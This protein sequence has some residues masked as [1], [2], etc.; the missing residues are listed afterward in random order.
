MRF[1]RVLIVASLTCSFNTGCDRDRHST[2]SSTAS[3]QPANTEE[4]RMVQT[5]VAELLKLKPEQ[6]DPQKTFAQ[7]KADDLDLVEATMEIEDRLKIS[8]PDEAIVKAA[9]VSS[10]DQLVNKMTI[11]QF[12]NAV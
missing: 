2:P 6:I 12:A 5:V 4:L 8:I 1:V 9:G 11:A 10:T 3:T 7:L